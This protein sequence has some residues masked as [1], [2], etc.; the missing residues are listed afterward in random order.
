MQNLS[1]NAKNTKENDHAKH[2]LLWKLIK[3]YIVAEKSSVQTSFVNHIDYTIARS[4][5]KFDRFSPI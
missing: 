5:L 4:R 2:S 1:N 3:E